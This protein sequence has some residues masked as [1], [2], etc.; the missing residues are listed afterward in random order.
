MG[1]GASVSSPVLPTRAWQPMLVYYLKVTLASVKRIFMAKYKSEDLL[2]DL[3]ADVNRIKESAAFFESSDRNKLA[4]S[5]D[6]AKWSVVQ[7]LEHLNAYN[8]YYLPRMEKE[9]A[10]TTQAHSA[11]FDSGFWGEKFTKMMKPSNVYQVKNK[12]KAMKAYTFS[13]NL[14]IDTV[15]K[16]FIGH[17][18]KLLQLL[19]LAKSR[20]LNNIRIA[21]T[22]TKLVKL[23]IGDMFRFLIAHE[24]RHMIQARNMLK[25]VGITTEKF[26]VILQA[27][28]R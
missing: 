20:D 1:Q 25:E 27:V 8:R 5:P 2:N 21:T 6:K 13:N 23:K 18:D 28:P 22:L 16:E 7:V 9:L 19:E 26:P 15:L 4:Y 24:Q 10:V 12:M 14:N 3:I 11:W 17:Q